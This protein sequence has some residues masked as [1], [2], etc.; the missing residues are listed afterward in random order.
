MVN[1]RYVGKCFVI[2]LLN[3]ANNVVGLNV[4]GLGKLNFGEFVIF[5]NLS[6]HLNITCG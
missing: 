1:T 6:K 5:V 4:A 2:K 3:V